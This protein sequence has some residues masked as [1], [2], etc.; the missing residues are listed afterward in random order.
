MKSA[1]EVVI[2]VALAAALPALVSADSDTGLGGAPGPVQEAEP[3]QPP[4]PV[5]SSPVYLKDRGTG[6]R[7]SMFGTYVRRGELLV[8][9]FFEYYWDQNIQYKP[10]EFGYGLDRD[11]RGRYRASEGLT[12][13]AYGLTDRLAIE[14]EA[15]VIRAS[16]RKAPDDFSSMPETLKEA[17]LGDVE[18]QLTWR[19]AKENAHRPEFFSYCEVVFPHHRDKVLI[20]TPD[21]ELKAGAGVIRG[22]KWGTLTARV[23]IE[24][25]RASDSPFD[26]G[27]W[28]VEYLKRVSPSWRIYVGVEGQA[29]DEVSLIT[30]AQWSLN[31]HVTIKL[32]NGLGLTP[33]ATDW[34]P[35]VGILLSFP[36]RAHKP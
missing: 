14:V 23:A 16:L 5:E 1:L 3:G 29:L 25:I 33:N 31:R 10:S 30:E 22:M 24:Y 18:G 32:N 2:A 13:F 19:W 17:G 28:A 4:P 36:A 26:V 11:F 35:E 20:G 9:P 12:F 21:W 7:T 34:A 27:E 6:I 8:Y 15:A